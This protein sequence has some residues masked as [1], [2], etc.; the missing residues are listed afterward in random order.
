MHLGTHPSYILAN[1]TCFFADCFIKSWASGGVGGAGTHRLGIALWGKKVMAQV[2][3][4]QC[5]EH[6]HHT[7]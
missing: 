3:N 5:T 7:N 2:A 6:C 4:T 1:T